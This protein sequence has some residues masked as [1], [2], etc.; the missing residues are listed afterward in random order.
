[1]Y[2]STVIYFLH[3]RAGLHRDVMRPVMEQPLYFQTS[4]AIRVYL[5]LYFCLLYLVNAF[6]ISS[7]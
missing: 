6:N 7:I 3:F 2:D 4:S 1:M 5:N